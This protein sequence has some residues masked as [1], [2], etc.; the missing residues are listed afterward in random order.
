MP[1]RHKLF[2][3]VL[4]LSP[5]FSFSQTSSRADSANQLI[6]SGHDCSDAI[7]TKVETL[8]ALKVSRTDYADTLAAY[9][10]SKQVFLEN[11]TLVFRFVVTCHGEINSIES[12]PADLKEKEV[13]E[14]AILFY[15]NLWLPAK[16]NGYIVNSY[17]KLTIE[18]GNNTISIGIS[19]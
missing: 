19:Q 13:F 12:N 10:V 15:S 17:V 1:L 8:P 16:Q 5:T 9:L 18:F 4:I 6:M 14:K 11:T 3:L 2:I 7:F